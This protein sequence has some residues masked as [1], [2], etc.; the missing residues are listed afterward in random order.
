MRLRKGYFRRERMHSDR[1]SVLWSM[2]ICEL[3]IGMP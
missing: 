2:R 3:D 1:R